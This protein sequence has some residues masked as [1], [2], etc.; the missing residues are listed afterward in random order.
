MNHIETNTVRKAIS[1][2][3]IDCLAA[4]RQ[5]G[6]E[7]ALRQDWS[8][9]RIPAS[10]DATEV[11]LYRQTYRITAEHALA[12]VVDVRKWSRE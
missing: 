11:E 5:N 8:N 12:L 10:V 4:V 2:A 1:D 3:V 9:P 6:P 7:K